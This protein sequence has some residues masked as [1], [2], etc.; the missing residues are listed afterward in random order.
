M[1]KTLVSLAFF[2]SA[3]LLFSQKPI[4][5]DDCFTFFKFYPEYGG[6]FQYAPDGRHYFEAEGGNIVEYDLVT[7]KKGATLVAKADLKGVDEFDAFEFNANRSQVLL[8]THTQPVYRHSVL[9]DYWVYDLKTKHLQQL[10]I[11]GPV[12]FAVFSPQGDKIAFVAGNNL[13]YKIL[14]NEKIVQI[15]GDGQAN[16]VINGLPDWVYEEEFSPVD[17]DGMVATKWSP[18]GRRIAFL[19]FDESKVPT[20]GLTWYDKEMYPRRSRFKYPKVGE[21]NSVV[22][23]HIFDLQEG[24][25]LGTVLGPEPDDYVPRIHWTYDNEL[26]ITRLNRMQDTLELLVAQP[27]RGIFDRETGV[28]EL[29]S[30]LLLRETDPA[31]VELETD[32]K[33]I[34]LKDGQHFL[35][36]SEQRLQPY[37]PIYHGPSGPPA[38]APVALTKALST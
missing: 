28:T 6:S 19:R 11:G 20:M 14:D 21:L 32:N 5:L 16:S 8:R 30:R 15:T 3:A 29:P 24:R 26:V 10:Y 23:A 9:A 35:W 13:H 33:L 4:T 1:K 36:T 38:R 34:F 2:L 27:Q 17:G 37:L 25:I 22:T 12:Q 31:Y 18:D 7:G